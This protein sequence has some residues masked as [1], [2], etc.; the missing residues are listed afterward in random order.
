MC[1]NQNKA[2]L[3]QGIATVKPIP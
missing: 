3:L 1:S 2:L